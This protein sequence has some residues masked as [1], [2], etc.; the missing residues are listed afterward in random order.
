VDDTDA[1]DI[2]ARCGGRL[3]LALVVALA[4]VSPEDAQ[5]LL[6]S[7]NGQVRAAVKAAFG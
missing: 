3:K 6:E 1:S 4:D 7:H 2:L 5:S